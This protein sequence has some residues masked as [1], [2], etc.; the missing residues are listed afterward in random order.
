[1][2]LSKNEVLYVGNLARL[3]VNESDIDKFSQQLSDILVYIEKLNSI[4]TDNIEPMAHA[5][6]VFNAFREDNVTN[7]SGKEA[8]LSNAPDKDED[9][10]K[11][12]KII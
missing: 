1:M 9:S 10:F 7:F 11:V 2:K 6:E 5:V 3:Y 8:A 12:P 4:N